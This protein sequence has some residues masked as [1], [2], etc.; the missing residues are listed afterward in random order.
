VGNDSLFRTTSSGTQRA[1]TELRID[2]PNKGETMDT[3]TILIVILVLFLL[4]GG[5][6]GYSRW[7]R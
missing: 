4:G 3:N 5:G 7:R 1:R 6:W 2:N